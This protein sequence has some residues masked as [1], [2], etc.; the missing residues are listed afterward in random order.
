MKSILFSAAVVVSSFTIAGSAMAD[1]SANRCADNG[2]TLEVNEGLDLTMYDLCSANLQYSARLVR[3]ELEIHRRGKRGGRCGR[4]IKVGEGAKVVSVTRDAVLF[5]NNK[6]KVVRTF[7]V[8]EKGR[9]PNVRIIMEND[10]SLGMVDN[11]G[12]DF[13][14]SGTSPD[15]C[16]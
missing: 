6:G 12:L 2:D 11:E 7:P 9:G 10:A 14:L 8:P 5:R 3:G 1:D 15:D 4:P 13:W 16:P